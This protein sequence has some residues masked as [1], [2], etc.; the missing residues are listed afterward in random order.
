M[1]LKLG[2]KTDRQSIKSG[3]KITEWQLGRL[4]PTPTHVPSGWEL[5][6]LTSVAKLESGHTPSRRRPEYWEGNV[7]W[8]SLHDSGALDVREIFSTAQTIAQLGLA[9]SSARLLPKG[10]VVFSRTATVGKTT[11]M[12]REMATSQ[13]FA[14]YICG[15]RLYNHYL[16]HLFRYMSPEWQRLMAGSTHNSIYM[17]V[18][19]DLQILLPPLNEQEAIAEAL[20]NADDL[21]ERLERLIAKKRLLKRG[22]MQQLLTGK[23]RL[24]GFS[25]EWETKRLA[26]IATFFSGGTPSTAVADYFAGDIPWITSGD[27]NQ[28]YIRDVKGRIS[29]SGLENS[30]AKMVEANTLLLA[31]YGATAGVTAIS[32]IR[33]AINQA[34]LAIVPHRDDAR[35]LY[36]K[37]SHL[38]GWLI[39]TYTQGGQPN[40]SGEIVKSVEISMPSLDEQTAIAAILSA[41]DAEIALLEAQLAKYRQLKQGLMQ[42]LLTGRIRLI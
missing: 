3:E 2:Q 11:V 4:L 5:V 33:A 15:E 10:T 26:D 35:F 7:P 27:L 22:V 14:N 37:L 32:E 6:Y 34:V 24:P 17:P 39:T 8:V 18:F 38:K 29:K 41:M 13:D 20:N 23:K 36:F 12:G 42:K 16:V 19:R 9:N 40:L 31:L 25:G 28:S 30:A 1:K 21:I